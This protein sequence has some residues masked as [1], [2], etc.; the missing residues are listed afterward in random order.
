[1]ASALQRTEVSGASTQDAVVVDASTIV[2]V[3][4]LANE[5]FATGATH[6]YKE[7]GLQLRGVGGKREV[8][9]HLP[10][11]VVF[12]EGGSSAEH[13]WVFATRSATNAKYEHIFCVEGKTKRFGATALKWVH[14]LGGE[15]VPQ[16][17]NDFADNRLLQVTSQA[18]RGTL[19]GRGVVKREP[20]ETAPP[21]AV[22]SGSTGSSSSPPKRGTKRGREVEESPP[23]QQTPPFSPNLSQQALGQIGQVVTKAV[24]EGTKRL[25]VAEEKKDRAI[26]RV[27]E[28]QHELL[29]AKTGEFKALERV[30]EVE[31]EKET[32]LG[33]IQVLQAENARLRNERDLANNQRQLAEN[34]EMKLLGLLQGGSQSSSD[35]PTPKLCAVQSPAKEK[36]KAQQPPSQ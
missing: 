12:R 33:K 22:A 3:K 10:I 8:T 32:L 19:G 16:E 27:K 4:D 34:R 36:E 6:W 11:R 14:S 21:P 25:D 1:M 26:E 5:V 35:S 24:R 9:V 29:E 2:V 31:K 23:V 28:V 17:V 18:E 30:K 7:V 13:Y 20:T 15:K